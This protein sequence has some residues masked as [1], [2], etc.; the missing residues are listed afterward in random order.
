MR[1]NVRR[2]SA[3]AGRALRPPHHGDIGAAA[4]AAPLR[5]NVAKRAVLQPRARSC[6]LTPIL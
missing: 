2:C 4:A 5:L 6:H 1:Q 3:A